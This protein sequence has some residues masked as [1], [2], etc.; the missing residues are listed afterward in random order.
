MPNFKCVDQVG[1]GCSALAGM[2]KTLPEKEAVQ[3][4][5]TAWDAGIRYFDTAPHY[6]NGMSEQRLG[7][8]LIDKTAYSVSTKVGRVL[9][10]ISK[11]IVPTNG[12]YNVLPYEQSFDYSYD[13]IMRSVESSLER[14]KLVSL[15]ILY[16]HDIGD[17]AVGTDSDEAIGDL[18]NSGQRALD[19]LRSSGVVK[20]VG[21]GVNTV[22]ICERLIGKM[23]LDEIL[24][25]GRYTLLDRSAETVLLGHCKEFGIKLVIGGVFNSGILATG[26]K[27]G[28]YFDYELATGTILNSVRDIEK[29]CAKHSVALP[30]AALQFPLKHTA[31]ESVL[32]GTSKPKSLTRNLALLDLLIPESFWHELADYQMMTPNSSLS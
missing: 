26:A 4:L 12:F 22:S 6:G 15:D 32:I 9:E 31:V 19:D 27:E 2:Y 24:L 7:N 8:F 5:Q 25:A 21:L 20:R 29:I 10:P 11:A 3:L 30:A 23:H 13:G 17:P 1:F 18:L 14:L 28:A 16:V